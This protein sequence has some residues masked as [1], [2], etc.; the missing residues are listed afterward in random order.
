VLLLCTDGLWSGVKDAELAAELS[1]PAT[2]VG[3]PAVPL[4]DKLL[5]LGQRAVT[6]N[7]TGSDNTSAAVLRWLS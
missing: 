1:A 7:G 5:E 4:R 3:S 2:P 6:R